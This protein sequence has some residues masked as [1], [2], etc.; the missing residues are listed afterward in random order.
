MT[1]LSVTLCTFDNSLYPQT[2]PE[3]IHKLVKECNI[4]ANE[5]MKLL[6]VGFRRNFQSFQTRSN[7]FDHFYRQAAKIFT[8]HN[9]TSF[10]SEVRYFKSPLGERQNPH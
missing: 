8:E 6:S 5:L 7:L 9:F 2:R 3:I 1:P 4:R 10:N